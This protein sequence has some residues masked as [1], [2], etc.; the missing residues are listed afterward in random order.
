MSFRELTLQLLPCPCHTRRC[1]ARYAAR[2]LAVAAGIALDLFT[3]VKF[4]WI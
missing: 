2:V 3:A 4:G 1:R